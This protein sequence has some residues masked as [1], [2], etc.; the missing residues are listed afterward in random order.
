MKKRNIEVENETVHDKIRGCGWRK[1][2]GL[3][4]MASGEWG[5]CGKLPFEFSVCPCCGRGVK[6]SRGW[7]WVE[8][9]ELMRHIPDA[10]KFESEGEASNQCEGCVLSDVVNYEEHVGLIWVGERHYPTVAD[11]M[12]EAQDQGVSRRLSAL[13][14]DY[15]PGITRV[16]L[17]HRRAVLV[18]K[19]EFGSGMPE[20]RPGVFAIIRPHRIEYIMK[21]D[22]DEEF[23]E[24]LEKRDITSVSVLRDQHAEAQQVSFS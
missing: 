5:G 16:L 23:L 12:A 22:E 17:A 15:V 1:P 20:R 13:P 14:N 4:L 6:P 19:A 2:G 21:G 11:F 3:Y 8:L 24:R 9:G 18:G 7:T 10:C